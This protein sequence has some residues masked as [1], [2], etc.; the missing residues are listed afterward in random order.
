L[1]PPRPGA[2]SGR[3][4]PLG[5]RLPCRD[6]PLGIRGRLLRGA[7]RGGR[8]C[9]RRR[10]DPLEGR[11][12]PGPRR[13]RSGRGVSLGVS[14]APVRLDHGARVRSRRARGVEGIAGGGLDRPPRARALPLCAD[15]PRGDP[16]R[17]PPRL[18]RASPLLRR[19]ARAGPRLRALVRLARRLVLGAALPSSR[20]CRSSWRPRS[21]RHVASRPRSFPWRAREPAGRPRCGG[22]VPGLRRA[23]RPA[24]RCE[25]AETWG[26]SRLGNRGPLAAL[27]ALMAPREFPR[28][29]P[30]FRALARAGRAGDGAAA[31]CGRI[32]LSVD[33]EARGGVAAGL[34]LRA[35]PP[36]QERVRVSRPR[37]TRRGGALRGGGARPRPEGTRRPGDPRRGSACRN[38]AAM[39]L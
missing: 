31:C 26:R 23:P 20:S 2:A 30:A 18:A 24:A 9:L 14:P 11:P 21:S 5:S 10:A 39:I 4:A 33:P 6:I 29:A 1:L 17:A 38:P 15:R 3:V 19:A 36:C 37:A 8:A 32:P 25:L 22:R 35:T 16:R 27:W 12:F 7:L 13:A 28:G 34:A